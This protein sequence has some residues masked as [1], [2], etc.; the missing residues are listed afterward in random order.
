MKNKQSIALL[1]VLLITGAL[2][3][4]ITK[5]YIPLVLL[6][7]VVATIANP[8]YQRV[9]RK[10]KGKELISSAIVTI[11][12]I[13]VIILPFILIFWI[14]IDQVLVIVSD[15]QQKL[16][17][18]N[19]DLTGVEEKLNETVSQLTIQLEGREIDK[20]VLSE[21][22]LKSTNKT[23]GFVSNSIVPAISQIISMGMGAMIFI[24]ILIFIF[25]ARGKVLQYL[26]DV[27]PL[28]RDFHLR[29]YEKF[30]SI[31]RLTFYSTIASMFV[32]G[33]VNGII[34]W[35]IGFPNALFWSLVLFFSA[36]IPYMAGVI[37]FGLGL[38]LIFTGQ[39]TEGAILLTWSV[40]VAGNVDYLVRLK[41]LGK[42]GEGLPNLLTLLSVMGGIQVFGPLLGFLYGPIIASFFYTAAVIYREERTKNNKQIK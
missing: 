22:I 13:L 8:L 1:V 18:G 42:K 11:A 36:I 27:T 30:E 41:I 20:E 4:Y 25:P 32:A 6:A 31:T 35:I 40:L 39:I 10:L 15:F 38:F 19:I 14:A 24:F 37:V 12:I 9:L 17:A 3:F 21:A 29:F 28:K 34:L 26:V 23:I 7:F 2:T 16:A 5:A 33:G